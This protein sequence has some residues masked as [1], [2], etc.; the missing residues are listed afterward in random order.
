MSSPGKVKD[1]VLA[2]DAKRFGGESLLRELADLDGVKD[3]TLMADDALAYLK[4]EGLE[5]DQQ[6]LQHYKVAAAPSS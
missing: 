3:V 6:S 2:Y 5:F 4:V 1:I